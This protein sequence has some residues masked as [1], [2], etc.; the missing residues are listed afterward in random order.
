MNFINL[1]KQGLIL[2]TSYNNTFG[3]TFYAF[4]YKLLQQKGA[5]YQL[6]LK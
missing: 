4:L 6:K 5:L 2:I 3:L 1:F